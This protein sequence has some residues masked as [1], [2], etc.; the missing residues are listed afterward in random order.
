VLKYFIEERLQGKA[1]AFGVTPEK[2]LD[3]DSSDIIKDISYDI[4]IVIKS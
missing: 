4:K 3:S 2:N 1:D